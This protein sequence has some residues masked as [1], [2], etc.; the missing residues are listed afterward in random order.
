MTLRASDHALDHVD[1][2]PDGR[3]L[4]SVDRQLTLSRVVNLQK[5][6]PP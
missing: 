2:S 3:R 5:S 6:P 4:V 1:W